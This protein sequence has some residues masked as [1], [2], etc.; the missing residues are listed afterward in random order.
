LMGLD[1]VVG[2]FVASITGLFKNPLKEIVIKI[3]F[4]SSLRIN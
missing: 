1:F 2:I 4:H 3:P